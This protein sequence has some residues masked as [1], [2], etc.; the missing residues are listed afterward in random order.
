L[1]ALL[2]VP[3]LGATLSCLAVLLA[4]ARALSVRLELLAATLRVAVLL[5]LRF[6]LLFVTLRVAVAVLRLSVFLATVAAPALRLAPLFMLRV[7]FVLL[8]V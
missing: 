1:G 7:A 8:F 2:R 5:L 4:T 3:S 6:A